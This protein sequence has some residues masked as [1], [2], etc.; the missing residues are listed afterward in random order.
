MDRRFV[1]LDSWRGVAAY[2]LQNHWHVGLFTRRT[3][4]GREMDLLG[5]QP[6]QGDIAYPVY[7]AMVIALSWYTYRWIE[8]PGRKWVRSRVL[9]RDTIASQEEGSRRTW[10]A[11]E[12][13]RRRAT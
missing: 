13:A 8:E 10:P 4:D 6:W 12:R 3:V 1:A 11:S 2:A 7:L 5:T 9:R